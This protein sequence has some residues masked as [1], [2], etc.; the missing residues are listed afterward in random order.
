[1]FFKTQK[2]KISKRITL[3]EN[4]RRINDK[5]KPKQNNFKYYYERLKVLQ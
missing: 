5:D 4:K 1:M 3:K 2:E